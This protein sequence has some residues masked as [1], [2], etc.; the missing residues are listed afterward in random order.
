MDTRIL[1]ADRQEMFREVLK[2]LLG[3]QRDIIVI[4]E[5]DDGGGLPRLVSDLKPDV[6]LMDT[7]LR[8]RSGLQV[9][10][11][12]IACQPEVRPIVLTDSMDRG[13]ILRALLWGARGIIRKDSP[14]DLL[15]KCIRS[16]MAGE[17]W[18]SRYEVGELVQN[19]R[20]LNEKMAQS[21]EKKTNNLSPRELQIVE[22]IESGCTNREI[23]HELC[24]SERTVKYHLTNIFGKC[25]VTGRMELARHS[26]KSKYSRRA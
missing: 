10:R 13:E 16:V 7:Q 8:K 11:E 6:L 2:R 17:C 12:V 26:L 5:T 4:G 23:A 20:M 1:I 21:E 25:G 18:V 19:L 22:A 3:S 9:L 24:L 15:F 14:V